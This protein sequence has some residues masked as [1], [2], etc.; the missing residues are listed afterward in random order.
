MGEIKVGIIGCGRI[1]DLHYPGYDGIADAGIHAVCDCDSEC[2]LQRKKQWGA[3]KHYT[4]IQEMLADTQIDAVEILTPHHLHE[5][6]V[7]AAARAG[8]HVALQKPMTISMES[9]DR[10]LKATREAGIVFKVSDNYV[11]YPP[12]VLAKSM[13]DS[14]EI[15]DPINIRIKYI[16]GSSGGWDVP[17]SAWEWR[18]KEHGEGLGIQTFD[19]GHHLWTTAWYLLGEVER[20]VSWIDSADGIVDC[21]SVIMWKYKAG[22]RYGTCEYTH[23]FELN[24]PSKYYAN[25]EWVEIT[26]TKGIICVRRCTGNILEGPAVSLFN[27]KEWKHY[28]DVDSDWG[29]GFRGS[30]R[31]FIA[32][33]RGDEDP[34]LSGQQAREVL[35]FAFAI[36]KSSMKRREVYLDEFESAWP[37]MYTWKK[38]RDE[39]KLASKALGIFSRFKRDKTDAS[40]AARAEDLTEGFFAQF[41]PTAATDWQ[42]VIGLHILPEGKASEMKFALTIA[43]ST[44]KTQKGS[45]PED[46]ALTINVP[47]GTW[48]AILL[49]R[50]QIV[51][52]FMQGVLKLE[53]NIEEALKL[54]EVFQL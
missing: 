39:K 23:S 28:N 32:A 26:G 13:M 18:M 17:A 53:G 6:M 3:L 33:I 2:A 54:K 38:V 21:P 30:T 52:E 25:D 1:S 47:A 8:K 37:G 50:K 14:G 12:F 5:E 19:H 40:L 29:A 27:G 36:Q 51:T 49:K 24:I 45:L 20:V 43:N 10:I 9:A 46:A 48:A 22:K 42:C 35:K 34:L 16:G 41:N 31:N 11:F 15:G 4:D 44:L 7:V